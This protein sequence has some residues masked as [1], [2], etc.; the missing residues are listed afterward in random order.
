MSYSES[1][2]L[3]PLLQVVGEVCFTG[4]WLS[5]YPF[6]DREVFLDISL[7]IERSRQQNQQEQDGEAVPPPQQPQF[8]FLGSSLHPYHHY[9]HHQQQHQEWQ[10]PSAKAGG[11][12][13]HLQQQQR[14]GLGVMESM[15]P[16]GMTWVFGMPCAPAGC[17]ERMV[18]RH[19]CLAKPWAM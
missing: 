8:Q 12:L 11:A 5:E 13:K 15:G 3:L 17:H 7:A 19:L 4:M 16:D 14:L 1:V 9:H 18:C 2:L 6:I 10:P